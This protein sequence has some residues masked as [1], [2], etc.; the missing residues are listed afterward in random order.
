MDKINYDIEQP[1]PG[2]TYDDIMN[3][4][5]RHFIRHEVSNTTPRNTPPHHIE[6]RH[7]PASAHITSK[8][9]KKPNSEK[10]PGYVKPYKGQPITGQLN[11]PVTKNRPNVNVNTQQIIDEKIQ[12]I[13]DSD[14]RGELGVPEDMN[15]KEMEAKYLMMRKMALRNQMAMNEKIRAERAENTQMKF[16]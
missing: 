3:R 13:I 10:M 15:R 12:N 6:Q 11:I 1:T 8:M 4:L 7:N 9:N 16:Q 5:T 2:I 14:K